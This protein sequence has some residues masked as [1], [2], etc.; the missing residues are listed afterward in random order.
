MDDQTRAELERRLE[1]IDDPAGA[2]AALPP[3]PLKDLLA[4]LAGL[5][6]V[7]VVLLWWAL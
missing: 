2:E 3:L 6:V 5:A 7:T 4:A 1:L